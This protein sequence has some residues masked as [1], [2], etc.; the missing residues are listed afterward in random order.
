MKRLSLVCVLLAVL[1]LP[2]YPL[3]NDNLA[4]YNKLDEIRA[5]VAAGAGGAAAANYAVTRSTATT[6]AAT[7]VAARA[8]RRAVTLYNLDTSITVYFKEGGAPAVTAANGFPLGPGQSKV[9]NTTA[10]IQVIAASGT[11]AIVAD[12]EYD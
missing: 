12:E 2:A 5:A 1:T 6:S 3:S 7:W 11:P 10:S 4:I 9:V 8:K